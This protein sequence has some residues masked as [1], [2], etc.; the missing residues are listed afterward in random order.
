MA[1]VLAV[2]SV[3]IWRAIEWRYRATIEGLD[4]RLKLRDDTIAHL[5]R[6]PRPKKRAAEHD[7]AAEAAVPPLIDL[8]KKCTSKAE[9]PRVFVP[10]SVST[11]TL[12]EFYAN[13]TSVQADRLGAAYIGKWMKVDG[14]V[15]NVSRMGSD[16]I[17]VSLSKSQNLLD[18]EALVTTWLVFN[19]DH[20]RVEILRNGDKVTAIGRIER[21]E[22]F[23]VHLDNCELIKAK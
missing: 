7:P 19:T 23:A 1:I 17:G 16:E 11:T 8:R 5:E 9:E 21:I 18:A 12:R 10:E 20:E 2:S 14:L 6:K 4:H 15:T 3:G 22:Q 13:N